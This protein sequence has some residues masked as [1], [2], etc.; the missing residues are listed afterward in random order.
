M[1]NIINCGLPKTGTTSL[2]EAVRLLGYEATHNNSKLR[3]QCYAGEYRLEEDGLVHTNCC[4]WYFS[5]I[6]LANPG[7]LFI[8]TERDLEPWLKSVEAHLKIAPDTDIKNMRLKVPI[9]GAYRFN[10]LRMATVWRTHR[11]L[12]RSW[13]RGRRNALFLN[14]CNGDGWEKL[15]PF[16]NHSVPDV[17][18]PRVG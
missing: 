8:I 3:K 10:R 18:F 16:L 7:T 14:I 6:D 13:F 17:P 5:D 9:W 2:C 12:T 11:F 1:G 4:E 15:C